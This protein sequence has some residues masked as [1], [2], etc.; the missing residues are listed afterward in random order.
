MGKPK[1]ASEYI[2]SRLQKNCAETVEMLE[3]IKSALVKL[4][5]E[6]KPSFGKNIKKTKG[7]LKFFNQ[8]LIRHSELEEKILFPFIKS[9][10]PKLELK[11]HLLEMENED[12]KKNVLR[13]SFLLNQTQKKNSGDRY[14]E[15][16][17]QVND[18]GMYLAYLL[19]HHLK[20]RSKC[21]DKVIERELR[22]DEKRELGNRVSHLILNASSDIS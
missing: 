13:F 18:T 9:H 8:E 5:Y 12:F 17:Q 7:M 10:F 14:G 3:N 22:E 4:R 11:V 1:V 19:R 20:A 16:A 15:W 21:I 2:V 6:G